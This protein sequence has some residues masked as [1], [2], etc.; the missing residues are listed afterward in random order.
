[1]KLNREGNDMAEI[2]SWTVNYL[3]SDGGR[4]TGKLTLTDDTLT[5]EALYDSS[6]ATI[7]KGLAGTFGSLA[8]TGGHIA[9]I[10]NEGADLTLRI[11]RSSISGAV[12]KRKRLMNEVHVT[13]VD[14]ATFVFGYGM[15]SVKNV[16]AALN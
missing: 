4:I 6:N 14:G 1:L 9:V 12:A 10:H 5:F 13:T 15:L 7:L 8:A 11:P 3:P 16:V 2:G